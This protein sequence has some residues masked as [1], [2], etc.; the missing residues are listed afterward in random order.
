LRG[1]IIGKVLVFGHDMVV[2][3]Q[4]SSFFLLYQNKLV[5]L[6]TVAASM[7]LMP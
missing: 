7:V 6:F 3:E 4:A 1:G 5:L 2:V